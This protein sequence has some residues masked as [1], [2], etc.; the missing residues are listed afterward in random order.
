MQIV[1]LDKKFIIIREYG[2]VICL[3]IHNLE[4]VLLFASDV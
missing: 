1:R 4:T 2:D 3:H